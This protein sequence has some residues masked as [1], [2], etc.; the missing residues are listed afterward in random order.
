M[1]DLE[2]LVIE[3]EEELV[4]EAP[5]ELV[6]NFG[7]DGLELIVQEDAEIVL[8][9]DEIELLTIG[10]QGPPGGLYEIPAWTLLTKLSV[11][12]TA[13]LNPAVNDLWVD[14]H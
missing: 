1:D 12:P 5:L 2:V 4:F 9:N 14:T 11:G 8:S 7:A 10:E 3:Q 13:P 6:F